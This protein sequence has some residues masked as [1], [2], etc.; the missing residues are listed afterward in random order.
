MWRAF[1]L[2]QLKSHNVK[3][4][5]LLCSTGVCAYTSPLTCTYG[6]CE[7]EHPQL[8]TLHPP[9]CTQEKGLIH[10]LIHS[11]VHRQRRCFSPAIGVNA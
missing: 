2:P 5:K 4:E 10:L 3:S 11:L 1:L 9:C 7:S 8:Y 6:L